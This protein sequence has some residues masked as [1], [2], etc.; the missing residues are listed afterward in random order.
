MSTTSASKPGAI[1]PP[2]PDLTSEEMIAR[3]VALR[4]L[5]IERQAEVEERTFYS[6]EMHQRF[7]D[8]G[9]YRVYVPRRYGGYEFDVTTF[10]RVAQELSR[11]CVSTGWCVALGSRHALQVRAWVPESPLAEIFGDRG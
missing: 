1:G 8:A 2:E 4:R 9:F 11:G 10:A 3:A 6:E 7:L 5:L